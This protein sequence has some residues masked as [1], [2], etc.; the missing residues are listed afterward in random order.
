MRRTRQWVRAT[1]VVCGAV[2]AA[3][4]LVGPAGAKERAGGVADSRATAPVPA[5]A[6]QKARL[7]TGETA[8]LGRGGLSVTG[9]GGAPSGPYAFA[10]V[11]GRTEVTPTGRRT[12]Q[13]TTTLGAT[14]TA[15]AQAPASATATATGLQRVKIDLVNTYHWGGNIGVWNRSTWQYFDVREE[16]WDDFGTVDLP[17]GDYLVIGLWSN[18][19][20]P[21][22]LL[23]KTFTVGTAPLTVTID[24]KTS[25]PTRLT[26]DDPS[27]GRADSAVGLTLPNG[28]IYGFA[29]GGATEV[30][31]NPISLPGV[32]LQLHEVLA[33]KGTTANRP[34]PYRYDLVHTFTNGVP[35]TPVA[36]VRTADLLK[37]RTTVRSSGAGISAWYGVACLCGG[38]AS[39]YRTSDV[40]A[41]GTFTHYLT[42]GKTFSRKV[43]QGRL[44][45]PLP[46]LGGS[47]GE[48]PAETFGQGPVTVGDGQSAGRQGKFYLAETRFAGP[49][50]KAGFDFS[51]THT[52]RVTGDGQELG[53]SGPLTVGD[54]YELS[55]A[56]YAMYGIH[57][58]A[59]RADH[60][61]RLSTR[62]ETDWLV[63]SRSLGQFSATL[64]VLD[65]RIDV[66]GLD[67]RNR[68]P[69]GPASVRVS[70]AN[71]VSSY[72]ATL[73]SV[74][75]SFDDGATWQTAPLGADTAASGTVAVD[76]PATA[77]FVSLR[78]GG[79]DTSG[80]TVTQTI[81]RAFGGP[82]TQTALKAGSIT[83]GNVVVNSAKPIVPVVS[84][85]EETYNARFT[86]DA[87][88][89]LG[90]AGLHFYHGAYANPDGLLYIFPGQC[91]KRTTGTTYDC[92]TEFHMNAATY[93]G[94]NKLAG[95]WSIAAWAHSAD[96]ASVYQ[97]PVPGQ[98]T[99]RRSSAFALT[100]VTPQPVTRGGTLTVKGRL[101]GAAWEYG[102]Q[103]GLAGQK[104][105]LQFK[106]AG[107]GTTWT[108]AA[109]GTTD[110]TGA[111]TI[112]RAAWNDG[113]WRLVYGGSATSTWAPTSPKYVDVR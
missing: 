50:G 103:T 65:A 93:I 39:P 13:A 58:T 11:G 59:A 7:S 45:L 52:Y 29:G 9:P 67:L 25:K 111:V 3:A 8:T 12:P 105:E 107:A 63:P 106:K 44:D 34:S 40:P 88:G 32:S 38:W 21:T 109:T 16:Q 48:A 82:G 6:S 98:A 108:I 62:I 69:A 42:P 53:R 17:P 92:T 2:V 87:P 70:L 33:R 26:V 20:Q 102:A 66:P 83:V 113:S 64:P 60:S 15:A 96:G 35:A 51:T 71:R 77:A 81:T 79:K 31:V 1:G 27:A 95:A 57:H 10:K 78:I 22:H 75:Y 91:T 112:R 74:A 47:Q 37:T 5:P 85:G 110:A 90:S 100:S 104:V 86:V 23:S 28:D 101:T 94:L 46:D 84:G 36:A 80:G 99:F 72:A 19:Q 49:T 41:P 76:V 43:M 97:G 56:P 14:S 4:A 68:V 89:G 18:W 54:R 30:L 24:A 61:T 55:V 73:T